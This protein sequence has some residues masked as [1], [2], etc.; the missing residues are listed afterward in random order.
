M[1]PTLAEK[2]EILNALQRPRRGWGIALMLASIGCFSAMTATVK[3]LSVDYSVFQ[4]ILF[5]SV[6][7]LPVVVFLVMRAGG[8][9]ALRT[10]RPV[11][12]FLRNLLALLSNFCLFFG[13]GFLSLA[14]ASA[15]Q[16]TSPLT[17]TALSAAILKET[18]GPRRWLAVA[19]GFCV[20]VVM[21]AP[22]GDVQWASLVVLL[23]VIFYGLMVICTRLLA[24]T[25]S[26]L[27]IFFYLSLFGT[28]AGLAAMPFVWIPPSA[29]DLAGLLLVGVFG[30]VAQVC[31][32]S[33]LRRVSPAILA[34]FEYTLII[35]AVAFDLLLWQVQPSA[36]TLIGAGIIAA[37]GL[38]VAQRESGFATWLWMRLR[39]G[40]GS[41]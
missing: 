36:G 38:Y 7:A 18:V 32:V 22:S 2:P 17:V 26:S 34:P 28:V 19:A 29:G 8:L 24:R 5:R 12:H 21:I 40:A 41:R 3:F 15:I 25:E 27:S 30:G 23:A 35:W 9:A 33:A 13:I 31:L 39:L 20:V 10:D 14:D 6:V 4:I 37:A 1:A 11:L 16:F